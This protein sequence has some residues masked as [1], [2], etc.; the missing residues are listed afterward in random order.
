MKNNT[1][2]ININIKPSKLFALFLLTVFFL[3][4]TGSALASP[5]TS[6]T[7]TQTPKEEVPT[8]ELE[9]PALVRRVVEEAPNPVILGITDENSQDSATP[10]PVLIGETAVPSAQISSP[11]LIRRLFKKSFKANEEIEVIV[12]NAASE[13][14][15]VKLFYNG[16]LVENFEDFIEDQGSR[17]TVVIKP[18]AHFKPGKYTVEVSAGS[19]TLKQDFTWGVLAINTNKSIYTTG[20]TAK[21]AIG[22][23]DEGGRMVC[24]AS[25][26]LIIKS[27]K[28]KVDEELSTENGKIK[29]NPDCLKREVR[30]NPDYEASYKIGSEIGKYEMTLSAQ[31]KNGTYMITD[32]FEVNSNIAFDVERVTA[33]RIFPPN[34]YPVE[35]NIAANQDFSGTIAELVPGSFVVEDLPESEVKFEEIKSVS[36]ESAQGVLGVTTSQIGLPF[37]EETPIN[38]EFGQPLEHPSLKKLYKAFNLSGHD[39]VDF[40][41]PVGTPIMA[42]DGGEVVLSGDGAYGTTVVVKHE[43]GK[44]YYGHLSKMQ[45]EVGDKVEK[46][47][48]IALSGD[49]GITTGPHLHFSIKLNGHNARNGYYGKTDPLPIL[50]IQSTL[51]PENQLKLITWN[52]NLKKGD[53]IKLS[54]TYKAPDISPEFYKLGPLRFYSSSDP[55]PVEGESRSEEE[56]ESSRLRSNNK[57]I[58]E[59]GRQWQI[60]ADQVGDKVIIASI[61][62][63]VLSLTTE[64]VGG[65]QAHV[66][67]IDSPNQ[68]PSYKYQFLTNGLRILVD[69][70]DG[71]GFVQAV[72]QVLTSPEYMKQQGAPGNFVWNPY[73]LNINTTGSNVL[74]G[75]DKQNQPDG[76]VKL[77]KTYSTTEE[78][79]AEAFTETWTI[80]DSVEEFAEKGPKAEYQMSKN[81]GIVTTKGVEEGTWRMRWEISGISDIT[82]DSTDIKDSEGWPIRTKEY[83]NGLIKV[84][85]NDFDTIQNDANAYT[86]SEV[87][88]NNKAEILFFKD[89]TTGDR[90]VDP[91]IVSTLIPIAWENDT[92]KNVFYNGS[93]FFV[94]YHKG[95]T[96][97]Y[98]KAAST[99]AGLAGATENSI[100]TDKSSPNI[101]EIYVVN[102]SKLDIAYYNTSST[103]Y[104]RTCSISGTSISCGDPSVEKE[105]NT[106]TDIEITRT[107][108]ANRIWLSEHDGIFSAGQTGDANNITS[109]TTENGDLATGN[110]DSS[111]IPFSGEDSILMIIDN[112]GGGTNNDALNYGDCTAGSA[113]TTGIVSAL[114]N[115]DATK[116]GNLIRISD[117]DFRFVYVDNNSDVI[118][119]KYNGTSWT[120]AHATVHTGTDQSP[121]M[122]YDRTGNQSYVL[123]EDSA[124]DIFYQLKTCTSNSGCSESAWGAQVNAD[125]DESD[126]NSF[127]VTQMHEAPDG[128]S[129]TSPRE[130]PWCYLNA[131]STN[132]D[133]VCGS[134]NLAAGGPTLEQT[135]RHGKWWNA[136]GVRQAFTF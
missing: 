104:V 18:R 109:W 13:K 91:T 25:L 124:D 73:G 54:Y 119:A 11:P 34:K 115:P 136:S 127:P 24:D 88:A 26:K 86:F 129:R 51:D 57:K 130:F 106:V 65:T 39:G 113:C 2:Y 110:E 116:V 99:I 72:S 33:T 85:V 17:K 30:Q 79:I 84:D 76:S 42:V 9:G 63:S 10:S 23:L 38:L 1:E 77:V 82:S 15:T 98:S 41:T 75:F 19:Q 21:I 22:V 118:E 111:L 8:E 43:W 132:F 95:S 14:V 12:D 112:D 131:N 36:E 46:G 40:A 50:G 7:L 107:A 114:D 70:K 128:S 35:I 68:T 64:Q 66:V 27:E 44:S 108:S 5:L 90:I 126:A 67:L 52:V 102:D 60:A 37:Q 45:V 48:Q 16:A 93:N 87:G 135:M 103:I 97:I 47:E 28:L 3:S 4:S 80:P 59:E 123:Y 101:F 53:K 71:F 122:F 89:G 6:A 83:L 74:Q 105:S 120:A 69:K 49:S 121:V 81:R 117:T 125:N 31:T 29:T 55:E 56:E 61:P 96:T 92:Q 62:R 20:D 94:I 58:F 133:I 32:A 134:V 100:I 78:G